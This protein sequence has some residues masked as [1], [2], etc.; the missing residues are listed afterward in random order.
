MNQKKQGTTEPRGWREE[1]GGVDRTAEWLK[2]AFEPPKPN[3]RCV[4]HTRLVVRGELTPSGARYVADPQ[5]LIPV[6]EEDY[7][8][9]LDMTSDQAGCRGC[10]G[11]GQ[12]PA[13]H[14]FEEV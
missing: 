12:Q 8:A 4:H 9:L 10:R 2:A 14:Y 1:W 5:E 6:E 11:S 13:R 3:L 7:Q